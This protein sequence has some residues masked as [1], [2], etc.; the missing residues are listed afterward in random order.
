MSP[1]YPCPILEF[2]LIDSGNWC[3]FSSTS[4]IAPSTH[5]DNTRNVCVCVERVRGGGESCKPLLRINTFLSGETY[6]RSAA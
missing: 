2:F 5:S 6:N 3:K 4:L 1:H